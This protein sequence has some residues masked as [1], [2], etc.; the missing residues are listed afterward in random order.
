MIDCRGCS[1]GD[2]RVSAT[3]R[4]ASIGLIAT[5]E[6]VSLSIFVRCLV[7]HKTSRS[8][9]RRLFALFSLKR[10]VKLLALFGYRSRIL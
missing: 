7:P 8:E 2:E 3:S 10:R 6:T 5:V 4:H 1:L 9:R